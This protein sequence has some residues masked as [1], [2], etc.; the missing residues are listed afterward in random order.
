[1]EGCDAPPDG[2]PGELGAKE[3]PILARQLESLVEQWID[4]WGRVGGLRQFLP[5]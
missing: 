1:M 3:A 4:A 2:R 5:R